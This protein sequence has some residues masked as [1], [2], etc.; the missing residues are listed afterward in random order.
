[1]REDIFQKHTGKEVS[2][3][4]ISENLIT[5]GAF[6]R[7]FDTVIE[8]GGHRKRFIIKKYSFSGDPVSLDIA[9]KDAKRAFENYSLA[10]K[11]GLRVFPTFRISKDKKKILMTTG[12]LNDQICIG[13]NSELSIV[14]FKQPLI[15]EIENLDEFLASFFAEGLKAAQKGIKFYNDAPFF[16]ISKSQ[17]TKIDFV[18]GDFD[19]FR[20]NKP[21]KSIGLHNV[22]NIRTALV[23]FW[24]DNISP[25]FKKLFL[26][27]V[28]YYYKQAINNVNNSDLENYS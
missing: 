16:I 11:A 23:G 4:V 12:F 26:D 9:E 3:H 1:M 20:E 17:P 15:E 22:Q 24:R 25:D 19:N 21:S 27:R 8:I 28:E 6:G 7:V 5:R 14:D 2:T 18:L 10:K 13:S